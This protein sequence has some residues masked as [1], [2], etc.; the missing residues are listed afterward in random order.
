M[1]LSFKLFRIA[2]LLGLLALTCSTVT[3][4][5][6][7]RSLIPNENNVY[8]TPENHLKIS[9]VQQKVPGKGYWNPYICFA[10]DG[11]IFIS[12]VGYRPQGDFLRS[13]PPL[14]SLIP[15]LRMS[16]SIMALVMSSSVMSLSCF[17]Y[18][19]EA[20]RSHPHSYVVKRS[21]KS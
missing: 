11:S 18:A 16:P 12:S 15:M 7:T 10:L 4:I 21:L 6:N 3:T 14:S 1:N 17:M 2:S 8:Y 20:F 13:S 19:L 5:P 9:A